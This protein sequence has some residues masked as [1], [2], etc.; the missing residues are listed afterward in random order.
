MVGNYNGVP[1]G[2]SELNNP[3]VWEIIAISEQS[4]I[5][6]VGSGNPISSKVRPTFYR[7]CDKQRPIRST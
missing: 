3:A 5:G 6:N 4:T 1:I 2:A 7:V